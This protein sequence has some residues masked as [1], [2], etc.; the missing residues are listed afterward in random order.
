[1]Y[2]VFDLDN[3]LAD[4]S[5]RTPLLILNPV[6]WDDFY[7]AC[8]HDKPIWPIINTLIA[9]RAAGARV[10]I[11]TGRSDVVRDQ[12]VDWLRKHGVCAPFMRMRPHGDHGSDVEMKR[13]WLYENDVPPDLVFEDRASVVQMWREEGIRCAQVDVGDF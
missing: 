9:F 6:P 1:M 4:A 8:V 12:T 7:A 13:R 2:V 5:H 11:W 3:T 10:E